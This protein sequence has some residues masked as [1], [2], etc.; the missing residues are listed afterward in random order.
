[1][2]CVC[3]LAAGL[4]AA[5][6][7]DTMPA[8]TTVAPPALGDSIAT[9][10]ESEGPSTTVTGI[11]TLRSIAALQQPADS[12]AVNWDVIDT[13]VVLLSFGALLLFAVVIPLSTMRIGFH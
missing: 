5:Q 1:M 11:D 10:I 2:L 7:V 8:A 3:I 9:A 4:P 13:A 6:A 12:G